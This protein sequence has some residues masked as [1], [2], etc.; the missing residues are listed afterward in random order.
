MH[1]NY[2]LYLLSM[3]DFRKLCHFNALLKMRIENIVL[4]LYF[5]KKSLIKARSNQSC[6]S[7][8][9]LF[10]AMSHSRI[11]CWEEVD[12]RLLMI[13]SQTASLISGPSF[14][15][16]LGCRCPND[17]CEGILDIHASRPF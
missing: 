12:S 9:E 4:F 1:L 13:G 11:G 16:N 5:K 17:P 2:S 10:N 8:R 6:S 14:A 3:A 7:P 15:H